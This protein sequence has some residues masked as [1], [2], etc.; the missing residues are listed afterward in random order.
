MAGSSLTSLAGRYAVVAALLLIAGVAR[1]QNVSAAIIESGGKV[2]E[3]SCLACH[4]VDG[5][6]V[7]YMNPPLIKTSVVLG[8][9]KEL[10]KVI[11]TGLSDKEIDGQ[12]YSNPMPALEYLSDKEIADVLT[13]IR[14]SF[15]NKAEAVTVA[16][17]KAVR[18][19]TK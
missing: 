4:Q 16:E 5:S 3:L 1:A 10:I 18:T 15:G 11:L 6:G 13:Y 17:V 8:D 7:P 9:K 14:N 2:Y 19:S 12:T